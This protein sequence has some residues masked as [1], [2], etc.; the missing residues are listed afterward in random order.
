MTNTVTLAVYKEKMS[1]NSRGLLLRVAYSQVTFLCMK[2]L[3]IQKEY[4]VY[5]VLL[6]NIVTSMSSHVRQQESQS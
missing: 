2:S 5:R 1:K 6:N 3:Y 4:T